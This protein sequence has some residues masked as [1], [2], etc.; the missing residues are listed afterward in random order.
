MHQVD[1]KKKSAS[2]TNCNPNDLLISLLKTRE[3][4]ILKAKAFEKT[5]ELLNEEIHFVIRKTGANK[6]SI[7]FNNNNSCKSSINNFYKGKLGTQILLKI[8]F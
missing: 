5:T 4:A 8:F 1:I 6:V 2:K 7:G 3:E